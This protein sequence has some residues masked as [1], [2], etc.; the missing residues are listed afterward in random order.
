LFAGNVT[1]GERGFFVLNDNS[2]GIDKL[3]RKNLQGWEKKN[4]RE[5]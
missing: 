3:G 4:V 2:E 5:V 1:S